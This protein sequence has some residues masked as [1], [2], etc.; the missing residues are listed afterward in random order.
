[1][2]T[3]D[4]KPPRHEGTKKTTDILLISSSCLCVFVVY[5]SL[6]NLGTPSRSGYCFTHHSSLITHHSL[7]MATFLVFLRIAAEI[8]VMIRPTGNGS[9][10]VKAA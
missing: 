5:F 7:L 6:G 2:R 10:N 1:M 8:T 4:P 9:R 3:A